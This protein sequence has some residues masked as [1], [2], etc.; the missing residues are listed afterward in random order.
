[1]NIL[2][3]CNKSPFPPSEGGPMAMNSI[4]TGLLEAGHNVRILAFNSNKY[5]IEKDSIPQEY[6]RQTK[7]DFVDIDLSIKIVEAFKN[8]FSDESYHVKRFLSKEFT[9][10]LEKILKKD[11]FD[12][13][14]LETIYM[15]PY[16]DTIREHSK[17][18]IVLRAHNVEHKIWERIAKKTFF[19]AKRWYLRHLIRTLRTFEMSI[20]DKVDGIAAITTTD[21]SF[22]RRV[23]ATP[24]IDIPFGVDIEKF[25]PVFEVGNAPTFYH[26]GSMNWMPNEE[27]IKWFL[28]NAWDEILERVPEAKLYLAGRNMPKWLQKTRKKNVVVVGEVPDAHEF[29]NQHNVAVVPLL[30]GSG[31]RIKIIESMAL[32]KTVITTLV[33]AEGIQYS[34]F[35]NIIIAENVPKMVE[36]ISRLYNHPEEA[37]AIGLNARRLVEELYDNKKIINRLELFYNEITSKREITILN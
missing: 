18:K 9:N 29:V 34:E 33:G 7:I 15:A 14:Q 2:M 36:N 27:G 31:M 30:S 25:D 10:K 11:R 20:L 23:T 1:M 24:V 37:E 16:I 8:L 13:V 32:G 5:H 26:I 35:E 21:A 3:L 22:F 17:A 28:N 4:V 19:F 6:R 12:I